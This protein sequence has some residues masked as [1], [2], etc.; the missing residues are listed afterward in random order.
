MIDI[1]RRYQ[2]GL[3]LVDLYPVRKDKKC[4]CGCGKKL[5]PRKRRW[6]SKDCQDNAVITFFIVKGDG[7]VIREKLFERDN[8]YCKS[9][10]VYSENWQA[11]HIIPVFL[12]GA[13]CGL[14]NFQSL[15]D[16]CHKHKTHIASHHKTISSHA[17][18]MLDSRL[19]KA[20]V[21]ISCEFPKQSIDMHI[22]GFTVSPS[23]QT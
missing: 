4:A 17:V 9:C 3:R 12:G 21:P 2:S 13:A 22:D 7:Y 20:L 5:P 23:L 18:C 16:F 6:A 11:D 1:F 19:A 10:G 15:C 14:D 8:G